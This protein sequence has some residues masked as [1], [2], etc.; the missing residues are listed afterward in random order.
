MDPGAS[1]TERGELISPLLGLQALLY[2]K[3][4]FF[5]SALKSYF[6]FKT[7]VLGLLLVAARC[8]RAFCGCSKQRGTGFSLRRLLFPQQLWP[9]GFAA[10]RHMV[11]S[12][13]TSPALAGGFLTTGPPGKSKRSLLKVCF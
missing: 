2:L 1:R 10:P 13:T 11:S 5:P 4:P 8:T 9:T 6:L 12:L 3:P 7:N